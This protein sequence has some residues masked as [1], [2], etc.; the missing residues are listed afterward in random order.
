MP[1]LT[2]SST[3][4]R[5]NKAEEILSALQETAA[6]SLEESRSMPPGAFTSEAFLALERERIFSKERICVGRE[7]QLL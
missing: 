7:D 5:S 2:P 1:L 3:A 6:L 4:S